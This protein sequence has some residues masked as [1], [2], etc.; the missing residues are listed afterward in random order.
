MSL[1]DEQPDVRVLMARVDPAGHPRVF[2]LVSLLEAADWLL[3]P[4]YR[5]VMYDPDDWFAH[6]RWRARQ[7]YGHIG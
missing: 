2:F 6:V 4:E 5:A 3:S 1:I 7:P